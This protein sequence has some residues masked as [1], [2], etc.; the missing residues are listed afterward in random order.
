MVNQVNHFLINME[1]L[2]KI[3]AAL[4][5][6]KDKSKYVLR[7]AINDAAKEVES[8]MARE[9]SKRY[10]RD[11]K[12]VKPYREVTKITKAKI[13]N[14]AAVI[15]VQDSASDFY[16]FTLNDRKYYPGS[17]GAPS[18]IKGKQLK[19]NSL[20]R[21]AL[22]EGQGTDQYK[23]FVVE[24]KNP[25]GNNHT[26]LAQ[27]VPGKMSNKHP[28]KEAIRSLYAT[29]K[30]KSEEYVFQHG[31]QDDVEDLLLRNIQEQIDRFL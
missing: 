26:A 20:Q 23:A 12:G 25:G 1:G 11:D 17:K 8:R 18:W 9:A 29:S 3:E 22:R 28:N 6:A 2:D 31:I 4:G 24:Y 27:R 7:K 13:G 16:E 15:T 19:N 10:A 21:L 30:P 14:L 5:K